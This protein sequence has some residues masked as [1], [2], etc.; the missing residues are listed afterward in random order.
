MTFLF[1][2]FKSI[3]LL[4]NWI[5]LY[6]IALLWYTNKLCWLLLYS[7][8]DNL[9]R[10][11]YLFISRLPH[12]SSSSCFFV[13][14]DSFCSHAPVFGKTLVHEFHIFYSHTEWCLFFPPIVFFIVL[15]PSIIKFKQTMFIIIVLWLG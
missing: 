5:S 12:L 3:L 9:G 6:F 1:R 15:F 13:L 11:Y 4:V 8:K 2:L 10:I 7:D 14:F